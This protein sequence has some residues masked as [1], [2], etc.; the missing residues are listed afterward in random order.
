M[1]VFYPDPTTAISQHYSIYF[2]KKKNYTSYFFF[3]YPFHTAEQQPNKSGPVLAYVIAAVNGPSLN[4]VEF[5]LSRSK[6]SN[7]NKKR[8]QKTD[9]A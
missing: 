4:G 1:K 6:D 8:L 9:K 3:L 7:N 5:P 2:F